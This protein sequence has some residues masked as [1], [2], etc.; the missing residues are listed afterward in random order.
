MGYGTSRARLTSRSASSARQGINN[1][2]PSQLQTAL[3]GG[4]ITTPKGTVNYAGVLQLR[5]SGMAGAD[6]AQRRRP[7]GPR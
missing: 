3:M 1:P 6:R 7:S 2:T 5:S 4:T